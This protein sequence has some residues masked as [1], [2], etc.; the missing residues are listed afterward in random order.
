MRC[1]KLGRRFVGWEP[2]R[3]AG[4]PPDFQKQMGWG[5]WLG[6]P[7]L[8]M[9]EATQRLRW[10]LYQEAQ[11]T[12]SARPHYRNCMKEWILAWCVEITTDTIQ[13]ADPANVIY[14]ATSARAA[15]VILIQR[16]IDLLPGVILV[17]SCHIDILP[18]VILIQSCYIDILRG[19]LLCSWLV[20]CWYSA[21]ESQHVMLQWYDASSCW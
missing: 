17:Q 19:K 14:C 11:E 9:F 4:S 12:P 6:W 5:P 8:G 18:G 21:W 13:E 7:H 2:Q 16:Y 20:L 1:E 3:L 15:S 10:F